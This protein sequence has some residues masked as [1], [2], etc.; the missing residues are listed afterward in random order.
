ME[1][2]TGDALREEVTTLRKMGLRWAVLASWYGD[3]RDRGVRIE[4]GICTLLETVRVKISSGCFSSCE[5]GCDLTHVERS[6]MSA[7]ASSSTVSVEYWIELLAK[8]MADE[9]HAP[10]LLQIPAVRFH[11]AD[12]GLRPCKCDE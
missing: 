11:Y 7:D 6:L 9:I 10:A 5:V 1:E 2:S 12:C 4:P 3:L 8:C